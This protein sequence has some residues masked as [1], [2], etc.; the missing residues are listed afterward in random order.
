[1]VDPANCRLVQAGDRGDQ[2][3][4][5]LG[6]HRSISADLEARLGG[7]RRK[8]ALWVVSCRLERW[9]R[10]LFFHTR[11]CC[12]SAGG[13]VFSCCCRPCAG[14]LGGGRHNTALQVVCCR[15]ECRQSKI[16]YSTRSCCASS[17][18]HFFSGPCRQ[19][20][21]RRSAV[22]PALA[23]KLPLFFQLLL[24]RYEDVVNPSKVLPQTSHGLEHHLETKDRPSP[25]RSAGWTPRSWRRQKR[26]SQ[27]WRETG[28]SGGQA[29]PGPLP[30]TW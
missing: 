17:G 7:G 30:S 25:R 2:R 18:G 29:A 14:S 28:S 6:H 23:G 4:H 16:S 21:G 15:L 20:A 19:T 27:P 12:P 11:S 9:Q 5:S 1:M 8:T 13:P 24:Q 3:L 26:S 10:D 22:S